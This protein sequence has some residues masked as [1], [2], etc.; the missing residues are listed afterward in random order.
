MLRMGSNH[1]ATLNRFQ[2]TLAQQ[3]E[4]ESE[5]LSPSVNVPQQ[6]QNSS[7]TDLVRNPAGDGRKDWIL[8]LRH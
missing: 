4:V 1:S 7:R 5:R 2:T 3:P 6:I 8:N